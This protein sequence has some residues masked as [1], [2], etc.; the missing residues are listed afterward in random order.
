[1]VDASVLASSDEEARQRVAAAGA[2]R[3]REAAA[4]QLAATQRLKP[5]AAR[6]ET[7]FPNWRRLDDYALLGLERSEFEGV[8]KRRARS[9]IGVKQMKSKIGGWKSPKWQRECTER[10]TRFL[11]AHQA[12]TK[13]WTSK[14]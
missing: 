5:E 2:P 12:L 7:R 8:S 1:M 11:H 6:E 3:L 9:S 4:R 14:R 13:R 10:C